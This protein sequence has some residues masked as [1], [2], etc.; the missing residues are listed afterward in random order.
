MDTV[1]TPSPLI[2]VI[3]KTKLISLAIVSALS[4]SGFAMA[5]SRTPQD[6]TPQSASVATAPASTTQQNIHPGQRGQWRHEENHE[7]RFQE[8]LK[9]HPLTDEQ[10]SQIKELREEH[11]KEMK[12]GM[13]KILT[14]DQKQDLKA[15]RQEHMPM[16]MH[17]QS[18][19]MQK[20]E[21]TKS[22]NSEITDPR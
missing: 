10:K 17:H 12:E 20:V 16:V 8:A 4:F 15:Y 14:A 22:N 6:S 1:E 7:G 2:G 19:P 9:N 13:D 5:A 11:V 18:K 21:A 3:M